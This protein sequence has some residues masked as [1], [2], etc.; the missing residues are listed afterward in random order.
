MNIEK[1][2]HEID[3]YFLEKKGFIEVFSGS[4]IQVEGW[5]KGELIYLFTS[6]KNKG[7]LQDWDREVKLDKKQIDF[8]V[9]IDNKPF[10]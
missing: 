6:L 8:K 4:Q 5:F 3:E 2:F 7:E 1:L 10:F 9:T